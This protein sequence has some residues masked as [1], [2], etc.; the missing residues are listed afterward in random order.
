[1]EIPFWAMLVQGD[2]PWGRRAAPGHGARMAAAATQGLCGAASPTPGFKPVLSGS[3]TLLRA[4]ELSPGG[5][6]AGQ[7]PWSQLAKG[8]CQRAKTTSAFWLLR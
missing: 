1:M 4:S 7:C 6:W 3:H 8:R 2:Q 5:L